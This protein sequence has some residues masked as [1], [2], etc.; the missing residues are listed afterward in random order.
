MGTNVYHQANQDLFGP[1]LGP[2]RWRL[3]K[4]PG[5][6]EVFELSENLDVCLDD[7]L[8]LAGRQAFRLTA[9]RSERSLASRF[10]RPHGRL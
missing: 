7:R 4:G 10:R 9:K 5:T 8:G 3:P 6:K 1:E 2:A